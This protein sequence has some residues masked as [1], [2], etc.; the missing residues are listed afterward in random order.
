M[1]KKDNGKVKVL[2]FKVDVLQGFVDAIQDVIII[3]YNVFIFNVN[4]DAMMFDGGRNK[5]K[6]SC[7]AVVHRSSFT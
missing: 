6:R 5:E 1:E 7:L 2:C 3:L 4:A